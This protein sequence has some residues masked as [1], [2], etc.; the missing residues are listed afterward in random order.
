VE[1]VAGLIPASWLF[2]RLVLGVEWLR[3]GWEKVGD[4]GWTA[5]PRGAAVEGFLNGAIGKSTAG[6]HPEVQHW[7]HNLAED[8]FLPNAEFLSFLVAYGELVVGVALIIGLLTRLS[9]LAGVLMNLMFLFAGTT[10][11]NPQM[12]VLGLAIVGFGSAA[13]AYGVDR[14]LV[15]WLAQRSTPQLQQA[16]WAV[17]AGASVVVAAFFAQIASDWTIWI[18]S[19]VIAAA[20]WAVVT[21]LAPTIGQTGAARRPN[22]SS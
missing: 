22:S 20:A 18:V 13:G 5:A 19:M 17:T 14:W 2:I 8:V 15:S 16:G 3:A 10:S 21:Q 7:F 6:E 11:S 1:R 9:A 12:L 4:A